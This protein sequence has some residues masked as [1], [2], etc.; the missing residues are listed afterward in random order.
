MI[1]TQTQPYPFSG[2]TAFTTFFT[3]NKEQIIMLRFLLTGVIVL[4]ISFGTCHISYDSELVSPEQINSLVGKTD[5]KFKCVEL[6]TS[7]ITGQ[8]TSNGTTCDNGNVGVHCGDL[9][10]VKRS[11]KGCVEDPAGTVDPCVNDTNQNCYKVKPCI[12]DYRIVG[13]KI[14]YSCLVP[15]NAKEQNSGAVVESSNC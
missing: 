7:S 12:C 6:C 2:L 1:T 15:T 13:G 3:Y 9:I 11:Y 14:V 4:S 10:T 5:P 8:C